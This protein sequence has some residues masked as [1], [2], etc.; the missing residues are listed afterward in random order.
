MRGKSEEELNR[1]AEKTRAWIQ[2]GMKEEAK[3]WSSISVRNQLTQQ[4]IVGGIKC[5]S[6][7]GH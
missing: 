1:E 7:D 3:K 2:Q 5:S 6:L 4:L